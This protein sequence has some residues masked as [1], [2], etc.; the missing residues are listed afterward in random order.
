MG[1]VV[2]AINVARKF[3]D[4]TTYYHAMRVAGYVVN[5][6]LIPEDR[7]EACVALAIMHDLIE[8]TNFNYENDFKNKFDYYSSFF[9]ECLNLITKDKEKTYE[10]YLQNIKDNY[11]SYPEVYWVKLSDM[12]DH[13]EQKITLTD[14]MKKKYYDALPIL[15]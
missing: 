15:L 7:M 8:D 9:E 6:N 12:K 3:Y 13:L 14:R 5:D 2:N 11:N 4:E 1:L 10:E